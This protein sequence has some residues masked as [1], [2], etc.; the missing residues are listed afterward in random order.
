MARV[1][2]DAVKN[3]LG[4]DELGPAELAVRETS[5]PGLLVLQ[6]PVHLDGRGWFKENWQRAK[7]TALGLPDFEPVQNNVSFNA[8]VGVTRG[9][10]AEPWDKLVSVSAGRVFGAWVDLR[11][12]PTFG[13][14]ETVE[15]G[16]DTAV[17][18]PYGVGNS[19]Q[20]LHAGTAYS[21]L[22]NDHWSAAKRAEYTFVNLAD[23]DLGIAWPVPLEQAELSAA[24]RAHPLLRDVVPMAGRSVA[25][26]SATR[27]L[28]AADP[29][30]TRSRAESFDAT[31]VLVLGSG[32]QLGRALRDAL[33]GARFFTRRELDLSDP[34][35]VAAL[36]LAAL[37]VD[38]VINAAA[39]TAVDAAETI[40]G[41]RQAWTVNVEAVSA[42][43]AACRRAGA[44]LVQVSTDYVFDGTVTEHDES[45]PLSPLGVYGQTKAAGDALVASLAEHYIVRTSWVVGHGRNFVATMAS[46]AARGIAP[47]VVDDQYGRLTFADDLAAGIVHLLGGGAT[48]H[49]AEA[50][51]YNLTNDGPVQTWAEIARQVFAGVGADPAA[52]SPLST[53]EYGRGKALAPRPVHSALS[54][55]K[56]TAA[57]FAPRPASVALAA[58]LAT[59]GSQFT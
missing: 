1:K 27:G 8:A 41:R 14:V 25:G 22:V 49:P 58:Y 55:T 33:P 6:L 24:D 29:L 23:P 18:V 11:S 43:V 40:E 54:L 51:I 35:A 4:Q 2:G 12:G 34:A 52:I 7:M 44:R 38:T 20:T 56:I 31:R 30:P 15:I 19:F 46:L 50:G 3:E 17:F 37:N 10:H 36:D 45:E 59:Y 28:R 42:L 9:V 21:Y 5:I 48:A 32:G 39:Y 53:A 57:G 16:P 47:G 13:R 26:D